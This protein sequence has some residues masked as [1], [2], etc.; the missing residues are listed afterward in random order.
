MSNLISAFVFLILG[1]VELAL[2]GRVVYPLLSWRHEEAKVTQT[3]GMNP[4]RIMM[5][6]RMQSLI[7][8][9]ILGYLLGDRLKAMMG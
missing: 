6:V 4:K 2:F 9:P 5:L 7:A 3:Q 1:I 8:M